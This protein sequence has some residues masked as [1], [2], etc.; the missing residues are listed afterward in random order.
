MPRR[1]YRRL[2]YL[3]YV[4]SYDVYKNVTIDILRG[5]IQ[6]LRSSTGEVTLIGTPMIKVDSI[7]QYRDLV[8]TV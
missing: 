3:L 6:S 5:R 7:D 4:V 1:S 8:L 2:K